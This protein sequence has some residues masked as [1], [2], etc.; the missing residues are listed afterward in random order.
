MFRC[1]RYATALRSR[2]V[3]Y[4]RLR[5]CLFLPRASAVL[6]TFL[7]HSARAV[8]INLV[9]L[10]R[11]QCPDSQSGEIALCSSSFFRLPCPGV[12]HTRPT[13]EIPDGHDSPGVRLRK[14]G[15]PSKIS[16]LQPSCTMRALL[17]ILAPP[18]ALAPHTRCQPGGA[19]SSSSSLP[20]H[21][22]SLDSSAPPAFACACVTRA[23]GSR[24]PRRPNS[25]RTLTPWASRAS[26]GAWTAART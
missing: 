20:A 12:Q 10:A 4:V 9:R 11:D 24:R 15:R 13:A 7:V 2:H 6:F 26:R 5:T 22:S 16:T 23:S 1:Y 3:G 14:K 18:F 8:L 17:Y 19:R 21:S 25:P